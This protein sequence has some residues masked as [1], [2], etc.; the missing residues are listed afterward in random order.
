MLTDGK[1]A[2]IELLKGETTVNKVMILKNSNDIALNR[3]AAM[4]RDKK[5]K[6]MFGQK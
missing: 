4:A 3:I 1:N 2:V 5:V 6:V